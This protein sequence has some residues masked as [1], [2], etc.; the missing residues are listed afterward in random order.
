MEIFRV[1]R[2]EASHSLPRL[3]PGHP[4]RKVHGHSWRVEVHAAGPVDEDRGW[5]MDFADLDA[6]FAPVLRELDHAHLNDVPG[7]ENPTSERLA[8]W[9]W[10]RVRPALPALSRVV[11]WETEAAGCAYAGEPQG[12]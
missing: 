1:F 11:V 12:R 9:V 8:Q 5:V 6:A 10:G 7:L 3:A 4:C 2:I